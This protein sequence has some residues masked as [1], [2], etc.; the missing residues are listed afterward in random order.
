MEELNELL[1]KINSSTQSKEDIKFSADSSE[2]DKLKRQS[3]RR[4]KVSGNNIKDTYLKFF[5]EREGKR[6]KMADDISYFI[7]IYVFFVFVILFLSGGKTF[8]SLSD[9]VLCTLL[10]TTTTTIVGLY[11]V[12]LK[13]Y[14]NVN[15]N[16]EHFV[17]SDLA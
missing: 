7:R 12:V 1:D 9:I 10:G 5:K 15:D 11:Y 14:Y 6:G 3:R 4:R 16:L 17:F 2:I 13:F 8:F